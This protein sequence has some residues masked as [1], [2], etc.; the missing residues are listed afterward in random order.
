MDNKLTSGNFM[1]V[2]L[3]D[4]TQATYS[5]YSKN[6]EWVSWG[7]CND[8]PE[9][10]IDIYNRNAIHGA[11]V[12]G[13]AS[14]VY[15]KGLTY[16]KE[17][18]TKVLDIARIQFGLDHANRYESWNDVYEKTARYFELFNGW[19]WQIIWNQTGSK[20]S[21]VY[22]MEFSKL[23]R[24][25]CG[26]KVFYCDNWQIDNNGTIQINPNPEKDPSYKCFDIFNPNIRTG[27]QIMYFRLD[28]P[29]T[30]KYGD[31]YPV[32]DYSG[33]IADVE[34]DIEITN[35]HLHNLKN[36]M[37]AQGILELPNGEPDAAEKKKIAKNF[38]YTHTGTRRTGKIIFYFRD[39]G[40]EPL[41]YTNISSTDLDKMFETLTKRIQQNIFTSHRADPV[42]FGVA[43]EGSLSD[44]GG[45]GVLKKWDKFLKTYVEGRQQ[46]ILKEIRG[47]FDINGVD[48]SYIEIEQTTPVGVELPSDP[49]ILQLF[50]TETLR[51]YYAKKYGIEIKEAESELLM[52]EL[53]VNENIKNL[54]GRQYNRIQN[55]IAKYKSGKISYEEASHLIQGFGLGEDYVKLVLGE[56]KFSDLISTFSKFAVADKTDKPSLEK[57][58][59]D[60]LSHPNFG[61]KQELVE[62]IDYT[63][64]KMVKFAKDR[65]AKGTEYYYYTGPLDEKTR[66][67]CYN[68]LI[69]DKVFSIEEIN[70]LSILTGYDVFEYQPGPVK[71][72]GGPGGPECR[73]GWIRF[74]GKFISTPAPTS[75]QI[76]KIANSSIFK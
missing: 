27:T 17:S 74:R 31:L 40:G 6:K 33:C 11:I 68:I 3:S 20:I 65:S 70:T 25:K 18:V 38:E 24:S 76:S 52:E 1:Q 62:V 72:N 42:L 51:N 22:C 26:K 9:Y 29:T 64:E 41:S 5:V 47:I 54:T 50:D 56:R 15:G 67:F 43:T 23:R 69:L 28:V 73:H 36:G 45:E 4:Y 48:G 32:P 10:L 44:T 55:L 16:N 58:I 21:E 49:N 39:K 71:P 57:S 75:N 66:K 63:P 60:L 30:H 13:K 34:T 53:P 19:A 61:V 59:L 7:V 2:Q 8:Y 12:K 35:F 46:I 37:W 14:Y